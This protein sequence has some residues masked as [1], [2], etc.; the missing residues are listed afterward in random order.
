MDFCC[1]CNSN[2]NTFPTFNNVPNEGDLEPRS[3]D[4]IVLIPTCDSNANVPWVIPNSLRRSFI[5]CPILSIIYKMTKFFFDN[6]IPN[7]LLLIFQ[8]VHCFLTFL[9]LYVFQP[10]NNCELHIIKGFYRN[11]SWYHNEQWQITA[12]KHHFH[13]YASVVTACVYYIL[14]I[15]YL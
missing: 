10:E 8:T 12:Q 5:V 9:S 1:Q 4:T 14:P 11:C 2:P 13:Q 7:N 15:T 6:H 3:M